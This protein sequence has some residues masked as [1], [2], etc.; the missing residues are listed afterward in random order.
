MKDIST[1]L[2]AYSPAIE[3]ACWYVKYVS[4][5]YFYLTHSLIFLYFHFIIPIKKLETH[6]FLFTAN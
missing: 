3:Q 5:L 4:A 1:P 6:Q 2:P